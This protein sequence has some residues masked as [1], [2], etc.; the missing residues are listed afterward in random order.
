MRRKKMSGHQRRIRRRLQGVLQ[1]ALCEELDF[2]P[3]VEAFVQY[4]AEKSL[5]VLTDDNCKGMPPSCGVL[6]QPSS[7]GKKRYA[8][9]PYDRVAWLMNLTPDQRHAAIYQLGQQFADSDDGIPLVFFIQ[10][11]TWGTNDPDY[12]GQV[13]LEEYPGSF[14]EASFCSTTTIITH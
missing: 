11:E 2:A 13:P 8:Q 3:D 7:P 1:T 6:T 5:K 12:D 4:V 9:Y 10:S 14:E